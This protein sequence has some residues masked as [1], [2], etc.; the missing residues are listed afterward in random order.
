MIAG[1]QYNAKLQRM[2]RA[3]KRDIDSQIVPLVRSLAP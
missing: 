1:I 2:V 3:I